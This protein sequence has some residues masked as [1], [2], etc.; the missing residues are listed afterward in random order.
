MVADS[1]IPPQR[2]LAVD[3]LSAQTRCQK[4]PPPSL[5]ETPPPP[6]VLAV[7]RTVLEDGLEHISGAHSSPQPATTTSRRVHRRKIV[8]SMV[9]FLDLLPKRDLQPGKTPPPSRPPSPRD[10]GFVCASLP[11][12]KEQRFDQKRQNETSIGE[13]HQEEMLNLTKQPHHGAHLR[14]EKDPAT[15][16]PPSDTSPLQQTNKQGSETEMHARRLP[17]SLSSTKFDLTGALAA[18]FGC[19]LPFSVGLKVRLQAATRDTLSP[20]SHLRF[21]ALPQ[22][23]TADN[24]RKNSRA[25][26]ERGL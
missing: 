17:L 11:D 12:A 10:S 14:R 22:T 25:F 5:V 20:T 23:R 24:N 6:P 4:T 26:S 8:G 21:F 9:K 19:K 16:N 7:E 2:L 3:A 1:P 18:S 15:P 13:G